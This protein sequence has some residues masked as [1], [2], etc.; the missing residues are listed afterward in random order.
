MRLPAA[1]ASSSRFSA[2]TAAPSAGSSPSASELSGALRPVRLSAPR[3]VKPMW[4]NRSSAALRPAATIR[5]ARLDCSA[6]QAIFSA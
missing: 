5:S 6:S 4:R 1:T 2:S 3:A